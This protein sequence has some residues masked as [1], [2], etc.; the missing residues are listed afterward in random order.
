VKF[1]LPCF[2]LKLFLDLFQ[3]PVLKDSYFMKQ[4]TWLIYESVLSLH[5][6]LLV[7]IRV[8]CFVF[9]GEDVRYIYE[10]Q[11]SYVREFFSKVT[12]SSPFQFC[13]W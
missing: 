6:G 3:D 1:L 5:Y 4:I 9:D 11:V 10:T 7:F 12:Q 13:G 2:L 8:Q